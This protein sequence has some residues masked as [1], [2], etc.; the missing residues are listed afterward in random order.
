MK[1]FIFLL[2]VLL[3]P[4]TTFAGTRDFE[5]WND[6]KNIVQPKWGYTVS[7]GGVT[8]TYVANEKDLTDRIYYKQWKRSW[9]TKWPWSLASESMREKVR[10]CKF[11]T[12]LSASWCGWYSYVL[13]RLS[14]SARYIELDGSWWESGMW[15]MLDTKT[16]KIILSNDNSVAKSMWTADGKQFIWQTYSCGNGA[17]SDPKWTFITEYNN[18][19]K[20]VSVNSQTLGN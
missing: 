15:R 20:I 5:I 14:P 16:G 17:C 12:W 18:F 11:E 1:K 4:L 8:A 6:F 3:F 7:Q 2:I 19:P 10:K 9:S 13:I